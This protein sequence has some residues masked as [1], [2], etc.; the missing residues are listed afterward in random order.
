MESLISHMIRLESYHATKN[1]SSS[2]SIVVADDE[3]RIQHLLVMTLKALGH[4]V[5]GVADNGAD[6]VELALRHRPDLV[7]LDIDMPKMDGLDAAARILG[8]QSVPIVIS[9]GRT[10]M[11]TLNRARSIE[12]Q[13]YLV[14]PFT[15]EQLQSTLSMALG[16]HRAMLESKIKIAK[17]T[18]EIEVIKAIDDAVALL[19]EKFRID[20]KEALEKL[21]MA[22]RAR[23]CPMEDAAKAISV[24]LAPRVA[25]EA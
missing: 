15:K 14:K 2:I 25:A 3:R 13:G 21:E 17:L 24:S 5:V 19:M 4:E 18:N 6:A 10:D 1:G 12:I 23:S 16:Q 20:R 22:A 9:T 8:E 7:V 11:E